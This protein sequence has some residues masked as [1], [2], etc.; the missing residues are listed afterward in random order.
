[1]VINTTGMGYPIFKGP[2]P[3][4]KTHPAASEQTEPLRS[5]SKMQPAARLHRNTDNDPW[6]VFNQPASRL[7]LTTHHH[8]TE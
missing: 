1:M 4:R 2:K 5:G 6:R 8:D 7:S 3:C